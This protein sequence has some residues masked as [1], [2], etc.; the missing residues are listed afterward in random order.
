MRRVDIKIAYRC[1]NKC[2]FCI[3]GKKR[4]F[5]RDKTTDEIRRILQENVKDFKGVVFTGGE[6]TIVNDFLE[7][8]DFA[9]RIGYSSIQIQTNGRMFSYLDFC[10]K[11][12]DAGAN[13][14]A[15]AIHGSTEEVHDS[16]TRVDGSF[17]QTLQGIKNLKSLDQ[18]VL[19]N[20]VVNKIN[21]KDIPNIAKM[22]V[23]LHV[24]SFQF[25]FM[26]INPVI[27]NDK[28][29]IDEIVPRYKDV[30][31]YVEEGLDIGINANI[32]CATEAMTPCIIPKY[33]DYIAEKYIP[34]T[35]IYDSDVARDF[36]KMKRDGA[37]LKGPK[38]S[39]CIFFDE[40]EGPWR[41]YGEIFGFDEFVPIT[42]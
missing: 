3:Q 1:N 29:L 10:K 24:Y 16:L 33:I 28:N 31:K 5:L 7:L 27:Q 41:D 6:V 19:T 25:A 12:I 2:K 17:D 37:K 26:H 14:F 40:C 39:E 8:V 35:F 36:Q 42:K 32:K 15:L 23:G 13:Q 30:K 21:H 20:T 9:K 11:T 38:C 22:L 34:E 4:E 18:I